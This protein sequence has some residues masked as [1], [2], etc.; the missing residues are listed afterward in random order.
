MD[1]N[2]PN[3][4]NNYSQMMPDY[5]MAPNPYFLRI[6]FGRRLGAFLIDY[7]ILM[8]VITVLFLVTG[9]YDELMSLIGENMS[10]STMAI[11][12]QEFI[13]FSESIT[14]LV[15]IA[16]LV[17]FSLEI[18]IGASIGKLTFGIRIASAD[19]TNAP[20]VK[21]LIRF[22]IKHSSNILSLLA[23]TLPFLEMVS[24]LISIVIFIGCFFVLGAKRQALHDM[25]SDTAVF[26]SSDIIKN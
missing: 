24:S 10:T 25:L 20:Y 18:F 17:Y 19:M 23:I 12:S 15:V 21:L 4:Y 3:D 5:S 13:N 22:L 16:T 2:S 6:G 11:F 26:Y 1:T 7:L 14:P 9:I 8:L